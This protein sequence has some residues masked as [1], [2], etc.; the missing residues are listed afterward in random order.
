MQ[1]LIKP[2]FAYRSSTTEPYMPPTHSSLSH[3]VDRVAHKIATSTAMRSCSFHG[4]RGAR[5]R[6]SSN[7]VK[8]QRKYGGN[9]TKIDSILSA[10]GFNSE[11]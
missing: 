7:D 2:C 9:Q 8:H 5:S 1:P 11:E 6:L 3:S 10:L 4:N